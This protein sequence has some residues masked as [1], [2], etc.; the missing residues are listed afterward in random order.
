MTSPLRTD[1]LVLACG[2]VVACVL[3]V[4]I[5]LHGRSPERDAQRERDKINAAFR[6]VGEVTPND[7][8]LVVD[9]TCSYVR[10]TFDEP[11][12]DGPW[13]RQPIRKLV[14]DMGCVRR[15]WPSA[16]VEVVE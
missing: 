14:V 7:F 16:T 2:V 12:V 6:R 9:D 8:S 3:G 5:V 10:V 13:Y 1:G 15:R 11:A 4:G